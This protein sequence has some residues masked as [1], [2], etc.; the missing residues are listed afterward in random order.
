MP[1]PFGGS[2]RASRTCAVGGITGVPSRRS[3]VK[4][5]GIELSGPTQRGAGALGPADGRSPA[6]RAWSGPTSRSASGCGG[7]R[8]RSRRPSSRARRRPAPRRAGRAA[9]GSS[10]LRLFVPSLKPNRLRGVA[11]SVDVDDVRPKPSCDQRTRRRPKPMRTRLRTACTATC[12]SFAQAW[13]QRSPPRAGRVELVAGEARAGRPA[14]PG[15]GPKRCRASSKNSARAEADGQRSAAT[16]AARAPR[17]CR[18]GGASGLRGRAPFSAG[19]R[20]R[21]RRSARRGPLAQHPLDR[22]LAGGG[23]VERGEVAARSATG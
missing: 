8:G 11:C 3:A 23:Q 2:G 6:R 14:R 20:P 5:A 17:R 12:G 13:M 15:G 18:P 19:S 7:R 9:S 4:S 22:R 21:V 1:V 16:A 10:A